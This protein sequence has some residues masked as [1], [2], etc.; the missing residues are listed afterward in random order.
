MAADGFRQTALLVSPRSVWARS[1]SALG[2][3][4]LES[5]AVGAVNLSFALELY[6]KALLVHFGIAPSRTHR[7]RELFAD[8]P[9]EV[10]ER[11]H[12]L[13]SERIEARPEG[14]DDYSIC[15]LFAS[16]DPD[17]MEKMPS[18]A[19]EPN[20]PLALLLDTHQDAFVQW[21]YATFEMK[22]PEFEFQ[23]NFRAFTACIDVV[24]ELAWTITDAM[25]ERVDR[26][27]FPNLAHW[28]LPPGT[29]RAG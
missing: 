25:G 5:L 18:W 6:L 7:L 1:V 2:D 20:P 23:F 15:G 17:A 14:D 8:L 11:L 29:A 24:R 22:A 28:P 4:P 21:R 9:P 10:Q 3:A 19:D 13:Y 27:A 12:E 26:E 16:P